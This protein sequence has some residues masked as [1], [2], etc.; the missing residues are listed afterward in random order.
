MRGAIHLFN[1]RG[2]EVRLDYSWFI[3]FILVT[4]SLGS[5]YFPSQHPEWSSLLTWTLSGLTSLLFFSSV[6]LHELAHSFMSQSQGIPVP[7]IT[8]FIFGGAAQIAE[9]PKA[10]KDEF[11][12]A[13]VGPATSL[14]IGLLMALVWRL[15]NQSL[16]V[17]AA[18]AGWLGT[19]NIMLAVFNLVPGFPLDGGRV[20]RSIIWGIS[21][22]LR[23]AT[24]IAVFV[25]RGVAFLFIILG[26]FLVLRGLIFNGLWIVFIGWFLNRAAVASRQQ[27]QVQDILSL[28]LAGQVMVSDSIF[29]P[30]DISVE[31]VIQDYILRTGKRC[32]PVL[33]QERVVGILTLHNIKSVPPEDRPLTPVG[34]VMT[35]AEDL[36]QVSPDQPLSRVMAIMTSEDVN[37]VPVVK[38]G[39]F[40]GMISRDTILDLIKTSQS[41]V[42][43]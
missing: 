23:K 8:L 3:I 4:W 30:A 1:V 5:H 19:I 13:L 7:R 22:D 34:Q 2:I 31:Q 17:L 36:K 9:E 21:G 12:M 18:L 25:G 29:V 33:K 35:P 27:M 14:L 28:H 10:A 41:L 24:N 26:I 11:L 32:F 16:P 42:A 39:N 40:Q 15:S 43:E 37:Q 38:D 20:L 6:L